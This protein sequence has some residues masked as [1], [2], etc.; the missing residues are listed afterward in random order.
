MSLS[1]Q[2]APHNAVFELST[3]GGIVRNKLCDFKKELDS[4]KTADASAMKTTADNLQTEIDSI[5]TQLNAL[6][7]E[8]SYT[9]SMVET[10]NDLVKSTRHEVLQFY[11]DKTEQ[12]GVAI[13]S[14][15][16]AVGNDQQNL[17]SVGKREY[18]VDIGFQLDSIKSTTTI[19]GNISLK[20]ENCIDIDHK[21]YHSTLSTGGGLGL[22]FASNGN[23]NS[24]A[25][26]GY[27]IQIDYTK[28]DKKSIT[29]KS[30]GDTFYTSANVIKI[31]F[32]TEI[33]SA[34]AV[35]IHTLI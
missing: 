23:Q 5:D 33:T 31:P 24:Q 14:K 6:K 2:H 34:G 13:K 10:K 19:A 26:L 27:D 12:N 30:A 25:L 32:G 7:D 16:N 1:Y 29:I 22:S 15:T 8:L 21:G 11:N 3:Q 28:G 17:L 18:N 4:S 9:Y 20:A 35:V